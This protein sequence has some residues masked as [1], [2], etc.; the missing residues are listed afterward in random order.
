[1]STWIYHPGL[2]RYSEVEEESVAAWTEIGWEH[3]PAGPE[4][5]PNQLRFTEEELA[6]RAALANDVVLDAPDLG[7]PED[8]PADDPDLAPEVSI[9]TAEVGPSTADASLNQDPQED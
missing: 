9:E 8:N 1:M 6:I 3:A 4:T 5:D 7:D 2:D